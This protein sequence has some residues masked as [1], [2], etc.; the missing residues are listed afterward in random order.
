MKRTGEDEK[1]IPSEEEVKRSIS[2]Y[3]QEIAENIW[4]RLRSTLEKN[5]FNVICPDIFTTLFP[6]RKPDRLP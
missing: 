5:G 1:A 6:V 3:D 4:L 2:K